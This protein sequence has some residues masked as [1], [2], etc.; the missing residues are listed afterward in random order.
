[1]KESIALDIAEMKARGYDPST[2][3]KT[4]AAAER[5]AE[6]MRERNS[7]LSPTTK[8]SNQTSEV[9]WQGF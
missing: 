1:M 5:R 3:A 4:I 8:S 6:Q 2:I 7:A 9:I